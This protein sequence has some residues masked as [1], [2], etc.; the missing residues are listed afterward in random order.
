MSPHRIER[1][2]DQFWPPSF[3]LKVIPSPIPQ[4]N[5]TI[6]KT[7]LLQKLSP[8]TNAHPHKDF[9]TAIYGR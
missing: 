4:N 7:N 9:A 6:V 8:W 2:C 3:T 5:I 1:G